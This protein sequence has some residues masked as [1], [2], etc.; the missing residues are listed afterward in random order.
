MGHDIYR[1]AGVLPKPL[2]CKKHVRIH[3]VIRWAETQRHA[4]IKH[5]LFFLIRDLQ[6]LE[7]ICTGSRRVV[8][9]KILK[10]LM[11]SSLRSRT[12]ATKRLMALCHMI[13][14]FP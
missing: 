7:G 4:N 13:L 14:S 6:P 5:K 2:P 1:R 10:K 3:K 8:E 12:L 11:R 9:A